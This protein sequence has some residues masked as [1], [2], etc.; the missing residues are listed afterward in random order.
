MKELL[1]HFTKSRTMI[2]GFLLKLEGFYLLR[3]KAIGADEWFLIT[4]IAA[5]LIGGRHALD[6][7]KEVK[8]GRSQVPVQ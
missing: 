5:S 6:V 2:F 4:L 3:T 7:Y 8:H 1:L